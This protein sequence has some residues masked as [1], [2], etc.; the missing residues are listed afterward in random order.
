MTQEQVVHMLH[1]IQHNNYSFGQALRY[2]RQ[3]M[4]I[5]LRKIAKTVNKTPAYISDIE[6]GNNFPPKLPLLSELMNTL[7]PDQAANDLQ[8][9][10]YD[11]AARERGEVAGDITDYIMAQTELRK[12]IRLA[13]KK[14]N[15]EGL[16]Q[17]CINKL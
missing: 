5:P 15:I 7:L 1:M 10:L 17:E 12:L 6:R 8:D 14:Q 9:Y 13:Q 16:W 2:I 11:L 4:G 3:E